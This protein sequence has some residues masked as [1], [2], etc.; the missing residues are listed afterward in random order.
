MWIRV[1]VCVFALVALASA[2]F[3]MPKEAAAYVRNLGADNF[4]EALA[5]P[6][7]LSTLLS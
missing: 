4:T 5:R 1:A 3:V 7:L 6:S 2:E